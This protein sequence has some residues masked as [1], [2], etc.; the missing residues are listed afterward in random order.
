MGELV[1]K[2]RV[3]VARSNLQRL[4]KL[5]AI[6]ER[7]DQRVAA[8]LDLPE[9]LGTR[10]KTLHDTVLELRK[11]DF[12]AAL[13]DSGVSEVPAQLTQLADDLAAGLKELD[14]GLGD[15][16]RQL[17]EKLTGMRK[18]R[19][20]YRELTRGRQDVDDYLVRA[21]EEQGRTLSEANYWDRRDKCDELFSEYVDYLRGVALRSTG[22][23]D[24]HG[25]IA[26]LFFLA[27]SLPATWNR[28]GGVTWKSLAVP[29]RVEQNRSTGASVL[30][31]GYP[32]WTIWALPLLQ[33]EFAHVVIKKNQ[34]TLTVTTRADRAMLADALAGLVT[35]P[36]YACA[37]LL[38]RL[39]PAAVGKGQR[40][41]ALRSAVILETLRVCA[42]A[43]GDAALAH[44]AE[45]LR[46]E[47]RDAVVDA[48]GDPE[49]LAAALANPDVAA[50]I[51]RAARFLGFGEL[52]GDQLPVWAK[53][54][55][56]VVTWSQNLAADPPVTPDVSAIAGTNGDVSAINALVL[57]AAWLAR[58]GHDPAQDAPMETLD[59]IAGAAALPMLR[60]A[61][62]SQR[63]GNLSAKP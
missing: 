49:A 15:T 27:D 57:D 6:V 14:D 34:A 1:L 20:E 56:T 52:T 18:V 32:E 23:G 37:E 16:K 25:S 36:A 7:R 9:K 39:D 31:I 10:L 58:V 33:H 38:L 62:T 41:P 30:R 13:I 51:E 28:P 8:V 55:A 43:A 29:S 59:R 4:E 24:E 3:A 26:D 19:E 53:R 44:L 12:P 22:L 40:D 17:V 35:G 5:Q 21:A 54:W 48:K 50:V 46:E 42:A 2:T 63:G 47:W 61:R 45:R 11:L 60:A